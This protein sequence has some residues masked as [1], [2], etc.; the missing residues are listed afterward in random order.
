MGTIMAQHH[1]G[2]DVFDN[3]TNAV[4]GGK[5]VIVLSGEC[6]VMRMAKLDHT[7]SALGQTQGGV[8][9]DPL[10]IHFGS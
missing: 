3:R 9:L 5:E 10:N 6:W 8:G 4:N 7:A 1:G 2:Q